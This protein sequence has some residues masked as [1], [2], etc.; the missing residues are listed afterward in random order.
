MW[1]IHSIPP[2]ET[3][4]ASVDS[5]FALLCSSR[6]KTP[7]SATDESRVLRWSFLA[8]LA[9]LAV[10]ATSN[11]FVKRFDDS[12]ELLFP[13]HSPRLSDKLAL[14]FVQWDTIHYLKI[15][16]DGYTLEQNFAFMPGVPWTLRFFGT[17]GWT[18][19]TFSAGQAVVGTCVLVNMISLMLPALLYRQ[20]RSISFSTPC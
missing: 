5:S 2:S 16:K 6:M 13:A 10:V 12:S 3:Y 9:T 15:A 1:N 18:S 19:D 7:V 4:G 14:P 8:R 17:T 20:A 11:T